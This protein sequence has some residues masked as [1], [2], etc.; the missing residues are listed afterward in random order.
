MELAEARSRLAGTLEEAELLRTDLT[1]R[2]AELQEK[3]TAERRR[4]SED[5]AALRGQVDQARSQLAALRQQHLAR[6][7][8][9]EEA[10]ELLASRTR[11]LEAAQ[12]RL[13]GVEQTATRMAEE[14]KRLRR[15]LG[16]A[17]AELTSAANVLGKVQT[18]A[19]AARRALGELRGRHVALEAAFRRSYFAVAAPDQE[20]W[21]SAQAAVGAARLLPRL[22]ELQPSADT[23]TASLLNSLEV[24]LT[25]LELIDVGDP[26]E[27]AAFAGLVRSS[28]A[29]WRIDEVLQADPTPRLRALLLETKLIL[30]GGAHVG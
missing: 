7:A 19:E 6:A 15:L 28:G 29:L 4:V 9:L 22:A 2:A 3:L 1:R 12:A 14:Q 5:L 20:S 16:A 11:E 27:T 13:A 10:T 26:A 24:L 21:A 8:D 18:E 17:N 23:E 25:R 30:T